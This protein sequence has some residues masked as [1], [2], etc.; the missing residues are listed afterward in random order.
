MGLLC[1]ECD[2]RADVCMARMLKLLKHEKAGALEVVSLWTVS[3]VHLAEFTHTSPA[4]RGPSVRSQGWKQIRGSFS[5]GNKQQLGQK[6]SL[7]HGHLGE[8]YK[9]KARHGE[10]RGE[11][12]SC[13]E[14]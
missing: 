12:T 1:K 5:E 9:G 4:L 8:K 2:F 10:I 13:V 7:N 14:K 6:E 3:C 11:A